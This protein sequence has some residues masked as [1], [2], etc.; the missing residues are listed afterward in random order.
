MPLVGHGDGS[1]VGRSGDGA[2]GR[3]ALRFVYSAQ[4]SPVGFVP[5]MTLPS[6]PLS[7]WRIVVL[8]IPSLLFSVFFML[9]TLSNGRASARARDVAGLGHA[10]PINSCKLHFE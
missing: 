8:M 3:L 5:P 7:S 10:P 2:G 6:A 4:S 9:A 1:G